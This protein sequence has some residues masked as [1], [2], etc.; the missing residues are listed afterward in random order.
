MPRK[1]NQGRHYTSDEWLEFALDSEL[2]SQSQS[3][4][5]GEHE[6][7]ADCYETVLGIKVDDI[8]ISDDLAKVKE[9]FER[10]VE[11]AITEWGG[12][13]RFRE[14]VDADDIMEAGGAYDVYAALDGSGAGGIHE[15]EWEKYF[16]DYDYVGSEG[17]IKFLTERVGK[18]VDDT[19]DGLI[20]N[21]MSYV[22]YEKF[23]EV[24]GVEVEENPSAE[25]KERR[26]QRSAKAEK[27]K[28]KRRK[29][30]GGRSRSKNPT[31]VLVSVGD[32]VR[33]L[34]F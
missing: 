2:G 24:C 3:V 22:V 19:G 29:K 23:A 1:K 21:E 30:R 27:A 16:T 7:S 18:Y 6:I 10:D 9:D 25:D 11:K 5:D 31:T 33:E 32:L 28:S 4:R 15:D 20:P 12:Q 26:R 13:Y 8:E 34:K 14:G 17:L